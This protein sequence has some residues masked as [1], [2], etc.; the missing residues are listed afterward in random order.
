M[1]EIFSDRARL[2]INRSR[3]AAEKLGHAFIG[4]EH[5]LHG[6]MSDE[7]C[8][9][10]RVLAQR[11][12]RAHDLLTKLESFVGQRCG[13]IAT[14]S[15]LPF[16]PAAKQVFELAAEEA[17]TFAHEYIGTEH[18]LL[19]LAKEGDSVAASILTDFAVTTAAL[20]QD[21]RGFHRVADVEPAV[22]P[23][24]PQPDLAVSP[25]ASGLL[26]PVL[27]QILQCNADLLALY[28]RMQ[29]HQNALS[30][31]GQTAEAAVVREQ[32]SSLG[33]DLCRLIEK[34]AR[35]AEL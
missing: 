35:K 6:L 22:P 10:V 34:Y 7:T 9:A 1:F 12:I 5:L 27:F 24:T 19:G 29:K 11:G 32:I 17:R 28:T 23:E 20:E 33:K 31:A 14:S 3:Q 15:S 21:V 4:P 30:A 2:A 8:T 13:S 26:P 18:L 25:E 16:T